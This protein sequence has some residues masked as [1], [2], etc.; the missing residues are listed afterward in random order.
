MQ[1][2]QSV[3][4]ILSSIRQVLSKE[5]ATLK[6]DIAVE[7]Q[8]AQA[9]VIEE[10]EVIFELT[11]QMQVSQ[12]TLIDTDTA[13]RTQAALDKL[14]IVKEQSSINAQIETELRPMLREWLNANLPEIVERIVTQEVQRIIN[15]R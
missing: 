14:N 1:D 13:V 8:T 2:E 9:P 4:E 15:R 3:S 6:N 11:P 7:S 12:G 10:P 5:A